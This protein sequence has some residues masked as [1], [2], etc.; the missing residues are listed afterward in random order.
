[1][2]DRGRGG[3]FTCSD[4]AKDRDDDWP[5]AFGGGPKDADSMVW[6]S[7]KEYTTIEEGPPHAWLR[8]GG[9]YRV[10]E[11]AIGADPSRISPESDM[12]DNEFLRSSEKLTTVAA[13]LFSLSDTLRSG[14]C[15]GTSC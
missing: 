12:S 3:L 7:T 10:E 14:V 2:R 8:A 15:L 11:A 6:G 1:M 13:Q 5:F 9:G 4:G